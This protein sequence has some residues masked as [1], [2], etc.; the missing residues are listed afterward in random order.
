[1]ETCEKNEAVITAVGKTVVMMKKLALH[2][3]NRSDIVLEIYA[4]RG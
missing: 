3:T 1:M 2:R 4:R